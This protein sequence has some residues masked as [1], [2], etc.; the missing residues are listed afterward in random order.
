[1]F[2]ASV[3]QDRAFWLMATNVR[4]RL[5]RWTLPAPVLLFVA[6]VP[7]EIGRRGVPESPAAST[8]TKPSGVPTK[9]SGVPTKS[10]PLLPFG[11]SDRAIA[12]ASLKSL[13]PGAGWWCWGPDPIRLR[14]WRERETCVE[15]RSKPLDFTGE[16]NGTASD[17]GECQQRPEAWC[18]AKDP[19]GGKYS[20]G[21]C[22]HAEK[23]C[24]IEIDLARRLKVPQPVSEC[25]RLP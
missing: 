25:V 14:C 7:A 18:Y 13:F 15:R 12:T 23:T 1:M 19:Q 24:E 5:S 2:D 11:A 3:C 16:Q 4:R 9:P 17:G 20:D 21:I 6:C 8:S 10:Q 22:V